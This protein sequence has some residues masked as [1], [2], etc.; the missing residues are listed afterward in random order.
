MAHQTRLFGKIVFEV[1]VVIRHVRRQLGIG[2]LRG[3]YRAGGFGALWG[4]AVKGV[5]EHEGTENRTNGDE[6]PASSSPGLTL[7]PRQ[8][9]FQTLFA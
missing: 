5:E 4:G 7:T 2:G 9:G 3:R 1:G 8:L 6:P